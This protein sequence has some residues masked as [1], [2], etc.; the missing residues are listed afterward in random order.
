L[1]RYRIANA[2]TGNIFKGDALALNT[3][4][5]CVTQV[6]GTGAGPTNRALGVFMGCTYVDPVTRRP[7][8]SNMYIAGTSAAEGQPQAL[9]IDNQ[10]QTFIIQ[11]DA[12][13]TVGDI[14]LNFELS[15]AQGST[16]SQQSGFLLRAASR[17]TGAALLRLV[18]IYDVPG[19]ALAPDTSVTDAFPFVEV[20]WNQH[21]SFIVSAA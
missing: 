19:N 11:A 8:W 21:R 12:S 9:V 18:D 17:T 20:Q 6:S 15:L 7:T 13:V 1:N 10:D 5:G 4:N 16:F 3:T 14:G 2:F